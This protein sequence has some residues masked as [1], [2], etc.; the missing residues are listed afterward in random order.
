MMCGKPIDSLPLN[1]SIFSGSW[2]G[3]GLGVLIIIGLVFGITRYQGNQRAKA[4]EIAQAATPTSRPT[5]TPTATPPPTATDTPMP[6]ATFTVT[7]SPTPLVHIVQSGEYPSIIADLY[8]VNLEDLLKLNNI[9]DASSLSI[10]Q[11]LLIPTNSKTTPEAENSEPAQLI[12]YT[13]ESGDTLLGIALEYD[14]TVETIQAANPDVNLDLIFPGQEIV[15]PLAPPT[16]TATPTTAPTS[17][18]TPGP[19]Y[20][21]PNL[22]S[23]TAGEVVDSPTLLFNWTSTGLLAPDEFY[24]LRLTWANGQHTE[25]WVKNNS[26]RIIPDQRLSGGPILWTVS[27]MRQTGTDSHGSPTGINLSPSSEQRTVEWR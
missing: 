27:I 18:A 7:P 22:L 12:N 2:I 8:G 5:S 16:P 15:V 13:V 24:V 1:T 6:T 26:W 21:A 19:D 25:A 11:V 23:P 20:L 14:T 9:D 3:V 10:G 4:E 17:T